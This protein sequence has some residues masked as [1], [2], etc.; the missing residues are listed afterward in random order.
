M[1]HWSTQTESS[2]WLWKD[3]L[4]FRSLRLLYG[5]IFMW[6]TEWLLHI[7]ALIEHLITSEATRHRCVVICNRCCS[8]FSKLDIP[9]YRYYSIFSLITSMLEMQ[10]HVIST[11]GAC[12]SWSLKLHH[13]QVK[14]SGFVSTANCISR[15]HHSGEHKHSGGGAGYCGPLPTCC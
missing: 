2:R 4:V 10:N 11:A 12:Y 13:L 14:L 6:N 5:S 9:L 7:R 8:C 1:L 15:F 3:E